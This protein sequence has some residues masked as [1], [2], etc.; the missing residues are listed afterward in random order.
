MPTSWR[1]PCLI[2][3]KKHRGLAESIHAA[4]VPAPSPE[5]EELRARLSKLASARSEDAYVQYLY[6]M[7]L[8]D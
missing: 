1:A 2:S 5:Q 3:G 7:V 8:I 4:P 6:G